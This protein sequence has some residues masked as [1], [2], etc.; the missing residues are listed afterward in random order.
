MAL[1][2][3]N[4]TTPFMGDTSTPFQ[5]VP[6]NSQ[7]MP[8]MQPIVNT[9]AIPPA[10]VTVNVQSST[11][12]PATPT[13]TA[14]PATS[15]VAPITQEQ[16]VANA[17]YKDA[18]GNAVSGKDP[19]NSTILSSDASP[20]TVLSAQ[21]K[22]YQD[23]LKNQQTYQTKLLESLTPS[24]AEKDLTARLNTQR[25]QSMQNQET[26]LN[27]GETSSFAGGE[28]QR[29]ARNDA[30]KTMS[31]ESQ[32]QT[33]QN[34][35]A[36]ALKG[37]E[38]LINSND[39]SFDAQYKIAQLQ[40]TV[41]G[42]DKQAQETFFNLQQ[43]NPTVAY[44]YDKSKS[45]LENLDGIKNAI[46]VKTAASTDF[47]SD[48][49]VSSL[50]NTGLIP[51][52]TATERQ[53]NARR[54]MSLPE[55]QKKLTIEAIA[56]NALGATQKEN[57]QRNVNASQLAQL[58]LS[59]I[60][61]DM[62]NNPYKYG[63]NTYATFFGG[64]KDPRYTNFLQTVQSVVAPIRQSYFGASLTTGEQN[65]ANQFLPDVVKDDIKSL[66]IKLKN[67]DA[68]ARFT[69]DVMIANVLGTKRPDINDYITINADGTPKKQTTSD[70]P[71][72]ESW[73]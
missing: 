42:V 72:A 7:T 35:R 27:S 36:V 58:S 59:N 29:V 53:A 28:A 32:V 47:S 19:F 4:S 43:Q 26:A 71:Y 21:D 17:Y 61:Q 73:D 56:V 9:S 63:V 13:N 57:Y 68:I 5:S 48:E 51:G 34:E 33:L 66:V 3:A 16:Q 54:I 69:N 40:N 30:F 45:A 31:L 10:P 12:T 49:T 23:Y 11:P 60:D 65:S 22:F 18:L 2:N 44:T 37:L 14:T 55:Q 39:N 24:Q 1:N 46:G 70:N 8:V 20:K 6:F 62:I 38:T 52:G 25:I 50:L 64:K 67:V 15:M 41:Q